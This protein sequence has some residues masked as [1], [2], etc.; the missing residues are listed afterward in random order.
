MT[1]HVRT[2]VLASAASAAILLV[3][4]SPAAAKGNFAKITVQQEG[5]EGQVNITDPALLGFFAFTDFEDG[6]RQA[7]NVDG[8]AYVVTR[9]L[10]DES[11]NGRYQPWDRLRYFPASPDS[12]L[13]RGWV[14]Y[15]GLVNGSSEY[16]GQW[17]MST[18]NADALMENIIFPRPGEAPTPRDDAADLAAGVVGIA[19][20]L[21]IAVIASRMRRRR[22]LPPR[23]P[24][25]SSS[26]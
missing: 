19:A 10:L 3:F 11:G 25:G 14:F 9:F 18:R 2:R 22:A 5:V 15:E 17:Y 12:T 6:R 26:A 23:D 7:P 21:T 4:A 8:P 13:G 20:G 16:D 1:G 24:T